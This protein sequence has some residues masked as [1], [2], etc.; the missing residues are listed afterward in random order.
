MNSSQRRVHL[1][2]PLAFGLALVPALD[3]G[4]LS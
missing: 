1:V 3:A 4:W 2:I